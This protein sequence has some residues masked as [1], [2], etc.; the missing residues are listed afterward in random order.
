MAVNSASFMYDDRRPTQ[1]ES[2]NT[3]VTVMPKPVDLG[4]TVW[5]DKNA[6]GIQDDGDDLTPPDVSLT[7]VSYTHLDVYKRQ[8]HLP[9]RPHQRQE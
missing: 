2:N 9:S 7:P 3:L 6:N 4:D 8:A 5:I 1:N